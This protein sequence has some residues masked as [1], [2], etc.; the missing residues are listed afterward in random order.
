MKEMIQDVPFLK[1]IL[2]LDTFMGSTTA[3]IGLA[4]SEQLT[5]ILGL[6]ENLILVVAFVTLLY[7]IGA[8]MLANQKNVSI[9]LLK[10]LVKANWLWTVVSLVLFLRY[11]SEA[12][13][14]G[15]T[16][17]V[18]QIAVVG[19]LAYWESKQIIKK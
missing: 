12:K 5:L 11:F 17:L 14:L 2:W 13:I 1:K 9:P 4:L 3:I 8:L 19:G 18:L 6:P 16:F 10:L 7:G 15:V